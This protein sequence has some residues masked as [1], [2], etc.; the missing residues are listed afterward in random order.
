LAVRVNGVVLATLNDT[1]PM[2]APDT[3]GFELFD[4]QEAVPE[5]GPVQGGTL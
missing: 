3:V 4:G 5:L 1:A 2:P